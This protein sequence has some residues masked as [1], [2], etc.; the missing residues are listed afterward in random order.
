MNSFNTK[1]HGVP[2][3]PNSWNKIATFKKPINLQS[4]IGQHIVL[5]IVNSSD[6]KTKLP[7]KL[8]SPIF[9]ELRDKLQWNKKEKNK[10]NQL[11]ILNYHLLRLEC[12][13][14]DINTIKPIN[15]TSSSKREIINNEINPNSDSVDAEDFLYASVQQSYDTKQYEE[16]IDKSIIKIGL[17]NESQNTLS[18]PLTNQ[19][20]SKGGLIPTEEPI[21]N[22]QMIR[23]FSKHDTDFELNSSIE[24]EFHFPIESYENT[25][26]NDITKN[27]VN[28]EEIES[29]LNTQIIREFSVHSF[30]SKLDKSTEDILNAGYDTE[31]NNRKIN[32]Y[33]KD[34]HDSGLKLVVTRQQFGELI[35][36]LSKRLISYKNLHHCRKYTND[37]NEKT[38]IIGYQDLI[39]RANPECV[40]YVVSKKDA[41]PLKKEERT[42]KIFAVCM[43]QTCKRFI[44]IST[45]KIEDKTDIVFNILQDL[46]NINHPDRMAAQIRGKYRVEMKNKLLEKRHKDFRKEEIQNLSSENLRR[47]NDLGNCTSVNTVRKIAAEA[48]DDLHRHTD[49]LQSLILMASDPD[50]C[51]ASLEIKP[52]NMILITKAQVDVILQASKKYGPLDFHLDATGGAWSDPKK[53]VQSGKFLMHSLITRFPC[54][55]S[56]KIMTTFILAE[57]FTADQHADNI[58]VFLTRILNYTRK[59]TARPLYSMIRTITIDFSA[60]YM[61][62]IPEAMNLLTLVDYLHECHKILEKRKKDPNVAIDI[63]VIRLC[64]SHLSKAIYEDVEKYYPGADIRNKTICKIALS[65]LF[66]IYDIDDV[67]SLLIKLWNYIFDNNMTT[68]KALK[69][70]VEKYGKNLDNDVENLK[71]SAGDDSYKQDLLDDDISKFKTIYEASPFFRRS[72][73]DFESFLSQ[74][75]TNIKKLNETN[76]KLLFFVLTI[77]KK[78]ITYVVMLS[79]VLTYKKCESLVQYEQRV[80]NRANNGLI[81]AHHKDTKSD[82]RNSIAVGNPP[83]RLDDHINH[84]FK[85]DVE[86]KI[87]MFKLAIP[88]SRATRNLK[89]KPNDTERKRKQNALIPNESTSSIKTTKSIA[90]TEYMAD[91]RIS[92]LKSTK[93]NYKKRSMKY[94]NETP[95]TK[96]R[97]FNRELFSVENMQKYYTEK[98]TKMVLGNSLENN[99]HTSLNSFD[100]TGKSMLGDS[101][102]QIRLATILEEPESS[103]NRSVG[104]N[105][106]LDNLNPQVDI[107]NNLSEEVINPIASSTPAHLYRRSN[108]FIPL[109][110]PKKQKRNFVDISDEETKSRLST[111]YEEQSI[112]T[113]YKSIDISEDDIFLAND[114][115]HTPKINLSTPMQKHSS[116]SRN[117]IIPLSF[118]VIT[119]YAALNET[120]ERTKSILSTI[121]EESAVSLVINGKVSNENSV[122]VND[123][124]TEHAKIVEMLLESPVQA[125]KSTLLQSDKQNIP[126][127]TVFEQSSV[128]SDKSKSNLNKQTNKNHNR[129]ITTNFL[130]VKNVSIDSSFMPG[131]NMLLDTDYYIK[132]RTNNCNRIKVLQKGDQYLNYGDMSTLWTNNYNSWLSNFLIEYSIHVLCETLK[133][134]AA[135]LSCLQSS[136]LFGYRQPVFEN[137]N[138]ENIVT[139]SFSHPLIFCPIL[140]NSHFTVA[141]IDTIE[142]RF[143]FLDSKFHNTPKYMFNRLKHTLS[144]EC[145]TSKNKTFLHLAKSVSKF[146]VEI[147]SLDFQSDNSH[148]GIHVI[149]NVQRFLNNENLLVKQF[150]AVECR[151]NF[152]NFLITNTDSVVN[153]CPNCFSKSDSFLPEDT[154]ISDRTKLVNW[155]RCDGCFRWWHTKCAQTFIEHIIPQHSDEDFMCIMCLY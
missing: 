133:P 28:V 56:D 60:A 155:I 16:N 98:Q 99:D 143:L 25:M 2:T 151:K 3:A 118:P 81:E 47:F 18:M 79:P 93:E 13:D 106:A 84:I 48:R 139:S 77:L 46:K 41:L 126:T 154:N 7:L 152:I 20:D 31:R 76:P 37:I 32:F 5:S 82:I 101:E 44:I 9:E 135:R 63:V 144:E 30:H 121:V 70:I 85:K 38:K 74:S 148:C 72:Y 112:S 120:D 21:L 115:Q 138:I 127:S 75:K 124:K 110:S 125:N 153:N 61:K 43:H 52:F 91:M 145:R 24:Q 19:D 114:E 45:F 4:E 111:I 131:Q 83:I 149:N 55:D 65:T 39:R 142:N 53:I 59:F 8:N 109:S 147:V 132:L 140:K 137:E 42:I 51:I 15:T 66:D 80:A 49:P 23:E 129:N 73:K 12:N 146:K 35:D 78:Y 92:Q 87:K 150:N 64:T 57:V 11:R 95:K 113:L 62:A 116:Q 128:L 108:L 36:P 67:Y 58:Q 29:I 17:V 88:N 130:S 134:E 100:N 50:T 69:A 89:N 97:K 33:M 68:Y 22:S 141:I 86:N 105:L 107:L 34:F 14:N 71:T 122:S 136:S 26:A 119:N 104:S 27:E 103:I 117:V 54:H 40:M 123:K 10:K 1:K 96:K 6:N 94:E 90:N 102:N